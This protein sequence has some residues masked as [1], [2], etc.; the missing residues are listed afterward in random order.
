M[1]T[2]DRITELEQ[3]VTVLEEKWAALVRG[4]RREG[5]DPLVGM[6]A[7]KV[8]LSAINGSGIAHAALQEA[9]PELLIE[10]NT[11]T[12]SVLLVTSREKR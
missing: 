2:S 5:V 6:D 11:V 4:A 1:D 12:P 3:R 7:G 9:Y 8:W 10:R